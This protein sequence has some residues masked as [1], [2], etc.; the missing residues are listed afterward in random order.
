MSLDNE[1]A[2]FRMPISLRW[3]DL[4][5]FNHVNKSNFLTYL[6]EARIRWFDS[7]GEEWVTDAFAPLLAAVQMNYRQPIPYPSSVI[8]EL[9]A[10]RALR[11]RQARD[12]AVHAV[13]H[14]RREDGDGRP[15]EALVH[16][17]HDREEAGEEREQR[18]GVGQ[19]VDRLAPAPRQRVGH[20]RDRRQGA[21]LAAA[22][23]HAERRQGN[24]S[25]RMVVVAYTLSPTATFGR[26]VSG[27]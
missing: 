22:E 9:F 23:A 5:S 16:R 26:A 24:R 27:R 1:K 10:E 6:E 13:E 7:L 15:L 17:L 11:V 20:R 4:D 14:H 12:A 18:E 8:V 19:Q 21:G 3:R 25:A 2:L